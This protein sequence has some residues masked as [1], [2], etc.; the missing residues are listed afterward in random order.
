MNLR[1]C[2]ICLCL[3]G[4]ASC[5]LATDVSS[6]PQIQ[7]FDA[8][9][10]PQQLSSWGVLS[11]AN[12]RVQI[13]QDSHVYDLNTALFTDYALKL[14]TLYIPPEGQ[15]NYHPQEAFDLPVGSVIAKTFFYATDEQSA[16]VLDAKWDG[17]P[18]SLDP[19]RLRLIETRLL[20]KQADGWDALPYIWRGDD[21]YLAITGDL[22]TLPV[23]DGS[24]LNYLIPSRNQCAGC[25]AEN[26]TT[27]TLAPIG[28]KARHLH[29]GDPIGGINQLS[30]W[31]KRGQLTALP[32]LHSIEANAPWG[33]PQ[34]DLTHRARSYLDINCGHCHNAVGA[35]DTSG[36][37]LDYQPHTP[38]TLGV[39]KP[40]IAAGRGSGGHL[41]SIVPGQAEQ[42]IMAFRL[43]STNPATMMPELG[44]SL[45]HQEGIQLISQWINALPVE[46]CL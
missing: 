31:E 29:R 24:T 11:T 46:P 22:F 12:G 25:H 33:D 23:A 39:C 44:R 37:L 5:Q 43:K 36:L 45:P 9:N 40:P 20:V 30:A 18:A 38:P 16:V 17:D 27:G 1:I 32:A 4:S 26:H 13:A 2:F 6:A 19:T 8:E 7:F 34:V 41:Y 35:A 21:A 10:Y 3:L 28:I 15:A 42:S 14:R